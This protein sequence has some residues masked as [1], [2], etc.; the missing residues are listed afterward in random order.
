MISK[1]TGIFHQ[2]DGTSRIGSSLSHHAPERPAYSAG[3][4]SD[5]VRFSG[6]AN[7]KPVP[8]SPDLDALANGQTLILGRARAEDNPNM[9]TLNGS[10]VSRFHAQL[11]KI[12][13]DHYTVCDGFGTQSS[14]NGTFVNGQPI[15]QEPVPV[16]K[17]DRIQL[18]QQI[19]WTLG[20]PILERASISDDIQA[21][22]IPDRLI[23]GRL[24]PADVSDENFHRVDTNQVSRVHAELLRL[25]ENIFRIRD[26]G[27]INGTFV[28]N[29]LITETLHP[30]E[31]GDVVR[32]GNFAFQFPAIPESSDA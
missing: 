27:S 7:A 18:G 13:D 14:T 6:R 31:P 3:G 20:E 5:T 30:V 8:N 22:Q 16:R 26:L 21:M 10:G 29:V 25:G 19:T 17:G 28:N 2:Y 15:G 12:D 9:I 23:L 11:T 1:V 4:V 32:L 24:K